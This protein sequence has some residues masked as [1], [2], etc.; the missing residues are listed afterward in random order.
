MPQVAPKWIVCAEEARVEAE[1]ESGALSCPSCR[2]GGAVGACPRAGVAVRGGRPVAAT[3]ASALPWLLNV[4][5]EFTWGALAMLVERSIDADLTVS[6]LE[7]LVAERGAP[8]Y[9]Q[10]DNG[11]ELTAH[12]LPDWCRFSRAG[13]AYIHPG[14]HGRARSSNRS[15]HACATSCSTSRSSP[16]CPRPR[17]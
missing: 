4:V 16:A 12:A 14:P 2:G 9:L 13:A 10:M 7:R 5:D 8:E 15:T 17:P 1:L 11:P 6:V 3:E